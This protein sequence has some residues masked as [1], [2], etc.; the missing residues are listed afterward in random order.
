M[1]GLYM[2]F[3]PL[4]LTAGT[5]AWFVHALFRFSHF[6]QVQTLSLYVRF[7]A[8]PAFR[9]YRRLVYTCV[10]PL[11][12][13][14]AGTLARFVPALFHFSR[15]PQVQT[16]G[17]YMRF[18]TSRTFRRYRRLVYTCVFPLLALSAGTLARFIHALFHFSRFPQVQTLGLYMRLSTSRA[19]RRYRRL[20]YTCVF[21]LLALSAGTLARFVPAL[22]RFFTFPGHNFRDASPAAESVPLKFHLYE[23]AQKSQCSS[24]HSNSHNSD[25]GTSYIPA[26]WLNWATICSVVSPRSLISCQTTLVVLLL[27][28]AK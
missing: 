3:P 2:R 12:A 21:P 20:V 23:L 13:L 18:S 1:P 5:D 28:P 25:H 26:D 6:P 11:L 14:S 15:F 22:F 17:L 8:S 10:L 24:T 27:Y 4:T 7:S 19:F 9:R 16:L